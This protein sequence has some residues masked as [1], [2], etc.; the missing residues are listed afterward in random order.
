M[1]RWW[2]QYWTF[3]AHRLGLEHPTG[4]ALLIAALLLALL[5]VT[6]WGLPLYWWHN[7]C[8]QSRCFRIGRFP[9]F[10][11]PF[12]GCRRHHPD[13]PEEMRKGPIDLAQITELHRL[14]QRERLRRRP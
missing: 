13:I 9:V 11:S 3:W 7:S 12:R 4:P 5:V 14:E 10:G 8:H 1:G 6:A 2:G